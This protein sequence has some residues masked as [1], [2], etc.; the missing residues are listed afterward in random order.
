LNQAKNGFKRFVDN[1][2][3][4]GLLTDS[5]RRLRKDM[6]E[7]GVIM[8]KT[9]PTREERERAIVLN[10]QISNKLNAARARLQRK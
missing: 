10:A 3:L 1:I 2:P 9:N 7:Y 8:E 6:Q 4:L 5:E